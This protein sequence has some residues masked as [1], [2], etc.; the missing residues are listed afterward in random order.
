MGVAGNSGEA[1]CRRV[2]VAREYGILAVIGV[3]GATEAI[4]DGSLV[5]VNGSEGYVEIVREIG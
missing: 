5:R 4:A 1:D 2:V 3:D